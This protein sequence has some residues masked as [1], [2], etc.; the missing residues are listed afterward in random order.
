[1]TALEF[2]VLVGRTTSLGRIA[3]AWALMSG[4]GL[5]LRESLAVAVDEVVANATA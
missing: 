2:K 5:V 3:G 1:M 4:H